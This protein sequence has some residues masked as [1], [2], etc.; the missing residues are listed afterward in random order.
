MLETL[1][2]V[3]PALAELNDFSKLQDLTGLSNGVIN[4]L[5]FYIDNAKK[6]ETVSYSYIEKVARSWMKAGIKT[7]E[8]AVKYMDS[9]KE[10]ES[11]KGK[12][13]KKIVVEPE[14]EKLDDSHTQSELTTEEEKEA[15]ELAARL[16]GK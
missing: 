10:K 13:G 16:L 2:G 12:R 3:K 4:I 7:A 11:Q 5:I 6:G 14:W 1:S 9:Q 15:Q 8:D